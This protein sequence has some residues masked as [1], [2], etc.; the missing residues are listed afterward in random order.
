VVMVTHD[1]DSAARMQRTV[2][3][4]QLRSGT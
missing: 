4:H 2:D 3:L 1:P